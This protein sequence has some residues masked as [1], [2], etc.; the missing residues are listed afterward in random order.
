VWLTVFTGQTAP[1]DIGIVL[2]LT[3]LANMGLRLVIEHLVQPLQQE[4]SESLSRPIAVV[5]FDRGLRIVLIGGGALFISHILG[6]NLVALM[7]TDTPVMRVV[8]A[9]VDV[10][11]IVLL[12]DFVWQTARVWID[13]RL[14]EIAAADEIVTDAEPRNRHR[15]RTLLPVLR[16]ALLVTVAAVAGFMGLS[17]LGVAVGP[18]VAGAGVIGIAIGF[19]AQTLVKDVFSGLLF[20]FDDA[21]RIGEYIERAQ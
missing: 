4:T 11:I 13:H 1:F 12:A 6:L 17:A 2:L 5:A 14:M 9:L 18:L 15:L 3:V 19:G 16:H 7:A 21:F 8:R 20:L 10:V